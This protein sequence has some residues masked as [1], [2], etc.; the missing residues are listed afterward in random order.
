VDEGEDDDVH[1]EVECDDDDDVDDCEET[2]LVSEELVDVA[3]VLLEWVVCA[4]EVDLA[5]DSSPSLLVSPL[6]GGATTSPGGPIRNG[7]ERRCDTARASVP[8]T[9]GE[10]V[11]VSKIATPIPLADKAPRITSNRLW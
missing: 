2:E 11:M 8:G 4:A 5:V 3:G 1:V 7:S 9:N 10:S 6:D